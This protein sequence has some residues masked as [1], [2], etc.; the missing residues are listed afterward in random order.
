[1]NLLPNMGKGNM[2]ASGPI[3][4][5][6]PIVDHFLYSPIGRHYPSQSSLSE[7]VVTS[8]FVP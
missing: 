1:M 3:A 7:P 6:G 8:L 4:T 2:S 5:F